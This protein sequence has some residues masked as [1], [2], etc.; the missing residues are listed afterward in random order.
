MIVRH[1]LAWSRRATA[2]QRAE[3]AGAL[4]RAYLY[5]D[6]DAAERSQAET[7]MM[8]LLDDP[9]PLVRRA[10]ADNMASA[11]AAPHALILSLASDQSDIAAPVLSRSPLLTD[12]DLIDC[13]A[14]GDAFAQSAIA[15]RARV[16][17]AVC[18]VIA[19]IGV[20]E[21]AIA[22]AVNPGAEVPE[23][24]LH[25]MIARFGDDGE[26][27]EAL[28]ARPC[29]P[30]TVRNEL[31]AATAADLSCFVVDCGWLSRERVERLTREERDKANVV[32]VAETA[33]DEDHQ[34]LRDLVAHLCASGQLTTSLL[35]RALLSG[36]RALLVAA[37]AELTGL[38][39]ARIAGVLR[40]YRGAGFA[41]LYK[42]AGLPEK[43]FVAF[44]SALS[45]LREVNVEDVA[46]ARLS[47]PLIERARAACETE[48]IEDLGLMALLRRFE[49]E[50]AREQARR[51]TARLVEEEVVAPIM[52]SGV[53][54]ASPLIDLAAFEAE[55]LA[56]A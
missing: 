41:A 24:A 1:F 51:E 45:A 2:A 30:A 5:A 11:A 52:F 43:Y 17:S 14:I 34:S 18:A 28:L 47:L 4:A 21:A 35:L 27:R 39:E 15:L 23:F 26:M 6:L 29:L 16:P 36:D 22:L 3:G 13:A 48:A 31:V 49:R 42:R 44:R 32:I 10:V 50:A 12:A 19:E 33:E 46:A 7:A 8:S 40:D 20:R 56:A 54:A 37:L 25:R 38:A 53:S 9:S 55:V